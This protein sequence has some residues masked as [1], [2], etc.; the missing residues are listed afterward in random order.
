MIATTTIIANLGGN[1]ND[2]KT[3]FQHASGSRRDADIPRRSVTFDPRTHVQQFY[4]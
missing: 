4:K 1:Q 2:A 3:Y